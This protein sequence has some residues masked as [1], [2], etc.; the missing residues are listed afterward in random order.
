MNQRDLLNWAMMIAAAE[1][2]ARV[3]VEVAAVERERR[4]RTE[5]RTLTDVA[6][7][8]TIID[9]NGAGCLK[10]LLIRSD[11]KNYR[12][13]AYI[14]DMQLYDGSFSWFEDISQNIDE[15]AAFQNEHGEYILHIT[16]LKFSKNI[17]IQAEPAITI[18]TEKEKP[19]LKQVFYKIDVLI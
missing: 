18:L 12:L 4:V 13:R 16:D 6:I 10:E 15:I 3:K 19:K 9:E 2:T 17:K 5:I 11:H 8:D 1:E 7:P 14:D